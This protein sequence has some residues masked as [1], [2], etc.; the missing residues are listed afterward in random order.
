MVLQFPRSNMKLQAQPQQ[1]H[2]QGD[3]REA[4][5]ARIEA[6]IVELFCLTI[7]AVFNGEDDV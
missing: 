1:R 2:E 4:Q 3:E 7:Q 5:E 6:K